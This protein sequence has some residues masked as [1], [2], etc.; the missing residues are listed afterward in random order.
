MVMRKNYQ[1]W[2]LGALVGGLVLPFAGC[3]NEDDPIS[4]GPGSG[5]DVKTEFTVKFTH[6]NQTKAGVNEVGDANS[7]AGM[8]KI[9]L[10]GYGTTA[11]DN[12]VTGTDQLVDR[13]TL[14]NMEAGLSND[15]VK[16]YNISL[17]PEKQSFMFYGESSVNSANSGVG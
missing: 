1:T 7:F 6:G 3:S 9:N 11:V 16:K 13:I 14:S 17:Q 5:E 10:I 4:N 8:E 15:F 12:Y 2:L